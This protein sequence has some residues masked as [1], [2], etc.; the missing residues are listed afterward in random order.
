MLC[1]CLVLTAIETIADDHNLYDEQLL[2]TWTVDLRPTPD[3]EPYLQTF[4]V[5]EINGK[6]FSGSFY[7]TSFEDGIINAD[8]GA[9]NFAFT[10][11]DGRTSYHHSG[12]L[13]DGQIHGRTHA[14]G[15]QMLSIWSAQKA[16]E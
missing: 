9:I 10:T 2:G 5:D 16:D 12:Y 14:P 13:K 11:A 4:T 1:I 7:G 15:R 3:S 6:N 8:W